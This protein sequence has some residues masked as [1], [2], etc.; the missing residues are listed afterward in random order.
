MSKNG[1]SGIT[2]TRRQFI[3]TVSTGLTFNGFGN[4]LQ[5]ATEK[6]SRPNILLI[7]ADDLGYHDLGCQGAKD[8]KTP[9]IDRL[10]L[11]GVRFRAGYVTAPQC[12]PSR[13]GLLTG[14]HQS[15]FGCT[16]NNHDFGLPPKDIVQ[17]LPEQLKSCGYTTGMIGKWHIGFIGNRQKG[18]STRPGH[19]PWERGF[20]YVLKHHGGMS[21]YFPYRK[22]GRKWMTDRKREPRLQQ[23]LENE[24]APT[25]QDD[26]PKDTYLTDI[27]SERGADFIKRHKQGKPWFLFL[28]YNAPHSPIMAPKNKMDKYAHLKDPKRRTLAAMMDS[29]DDGVGH[30]LKTLRETGQAE[31]TLVWFLSDNGGVARTKRNWNG[32]RND[33]FSGAKGDVFEGGIRIPFIVSWPGTI[34]GGK[35]VS[36]P[37]ISLDILPTSMAAARQEIV[38]DIH[39]GK[40]LLPW[41]MGK[42]DCPNDV[43]F[44][45][46]RGQ[47]N[48]IRI[49]TLKEIRNAR[50][51]KA[52]DGTPIPKH[53]F[54]DLETNPTELAGMQSLKSSEKREM[55]SKELDAWLKSIRA[56]AK[57]LT[58]KGNLQQ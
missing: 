34:P 48:A 45:S 19:H 24:K 41:L 47:Y 13:A 17:I 11:S 7:M 55:L 26:L 52:V 29:L 3:Q 21:H 42:T 43:L 30:V 20:D 6:D 53:N 36:D 40:N 57:K 33:P 9:N 15:R 5:A 25:Y 44:W 51:V 31:N 49:G 23:K 38:A 39:D 54:V 32:S 10:A 18:H 56:D 14:M 12:G 50:D 28:A 35:A 37:V 46:W 58:P 4:L 1:K 22:D 2:L 16:D 27:F 8:F